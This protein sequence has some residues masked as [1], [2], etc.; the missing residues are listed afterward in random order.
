MPQLATTT[1]HTPARLAH[2]CKSHS[3]RSVTPLACL[4]R[5]QSG[6]LR[7]DQ[8]GP[9]LHPLLALCHRHHRRQN[10]QLR[11]KKQ[12]VHRYGRSGVYADR[13]PPTDI[14]DHSRTAVLGHQSEAEQQ[15]RAPVFGHVHASPRYSLEPRRRSTQGVPEA[16]LR[17]VGRR[18]DGGN[19]LPRRSHG[20][21]PGASRV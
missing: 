9:T 5:V 18:D 17:F 19:D 12:A 16:C 6:W 3:A 7:Q 8:N 21:L 20:A 10:N 4:L 11:W 2:R 15:R 1:Q 14:G 13:C